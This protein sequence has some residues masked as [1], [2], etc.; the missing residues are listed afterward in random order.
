[1]TESNK[2]THKV[3]FESKDQ[4]SEKGYLKQIGVGWTHSE[5]DGITL[6]LYARPVNDS[7]LQRLV[8]LLSTEIESQP[9]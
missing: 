2:P 9:K 7:D 1:M 8:I 3:F 4:R 5:G 6:D